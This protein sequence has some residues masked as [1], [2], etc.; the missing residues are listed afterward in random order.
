MELAY[1]YV[2][3]ICPK[4][5]KWIIQAR[6]IRL[7]TVPSFNDPTENFSI[8]M[9]LLDSKVKKII[10]VDW[11]IFLYLLFQ[12]G[13][14]Q[15]TVK[16]SLISTFQLKLNEGNLYTIS[17]FGV[18]QNKGEYKPMSHAYKINFQATT[19]IVDLAQANIPTY[20]FDF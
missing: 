9:V 13:K 3:D 14:I 20:G 11:L 8:D 19:T 18:G 7:W 10:H 1:H 12:G 16:K 15:A 6:I 2:A 17:N 4:K 5:E